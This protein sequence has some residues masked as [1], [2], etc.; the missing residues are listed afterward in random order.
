MG[1]VEVAELREDYRRGRLERSDLAADPVG[2]FDGWLSEALADELPEPNA[3]VVATIDERGAPDARVVLLKDYDD[4]G[5][6]FYTN[7]SSAKGQQIERSPRAA[8]VF[9]W[10]RHERQVRIRGAVS[11]VSREETAAYFHSRPLASQ[12]GAWSSNQSTVIAGREELDAKRRQ[13]EEHHAATG[14]MPVPPHWGGYRVAWGEVEF[15]Q[16]RSSRLHDRFRFTRSPDGGSW[17]VE[18]LAP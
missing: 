2:Q 3:M 17:V 10:L 16:G 18:R 5:L 11:R 1:R 9:N 12:I 14:R 6:V 7:Y 15:W 13:L 8:L 4:R